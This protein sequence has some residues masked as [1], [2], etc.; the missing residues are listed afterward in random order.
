MKRWMWLLA[1]AWACDDASGDADVDP[2]SP[3][4]AAADVSVVGDDAA[5]PDGGS[6]AAAPRP[7]EV[8]TAQG[9]VRGHPA[10]IEG[11]TAFLG[12][13]FAAPPTGDLRWRPPEPPASRDETYAADTWAPACPQHDRDDQIIGE[14][15]CLYLNVWSPDTAGEAP[16][17]L[18]IHGGG[19]TQ[20]SAAQTTAEGIHIYDGRRLAARTGSVVV[21]VQYRLGHLGWLTHAE[22]DAE[23]GNSGN[24]GL[25]D[26]VA[27]LRWWQANAR[28]FGA[29]PGRVLVFGESAGGL[30]TCL[31]L[32]SPHAAGL[33]SAALMESG[34]CAASARAD[35]DAVAADLLEATACA[36]V[37]C[38]RSQSTDALL[39]A[40]PLSI[41]VAGRGNPTVSVDGD[42]VPD[43]PLTVIAAGEHNQV[44][45]VIGTNDAE[46][47]LAVPQRIDAAMYERLVR[48]TFGGFADEILAAY[49]LDDFATPRQAWV[50]VT[51]DAKFVCHARAVARA[52][53]GAQDAPVYRYLFAHHLENGRLGAIGAWHGL[54]LPFVFG[55]LN[56][57]GYTPSAGEEALSRE[58]QDRWGAFAGGSAPDVDGAAPWDV[59]EVE[60]DNHLRLVAGA[61][62]MGEG[63]HSARCDLW[64][65]LIARL[66][67]Q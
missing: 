47:A 50:Q 60:R 11:V 64:D 19:N 37:E 15:D 7:G 42:V 23:S 49:P 52:V 38:L 21:T 29:D 54:E 44:P 32:A 48:A 27:A 65:E 57:G 8:P 2:G 25:L 55:D 51:S 18:F 31:L 61:V 28:A 6:D 63:V 36:D 1:L 43:H 34:G 58:I 20:G 62:E 16:T 33:F 24:Y 22:L 39:A 41:D 56:V 13:P 59:Y 53:A 14:E 66:T 35:S 17:L 67:G 26:L 12:V 45:L 4:A 10:A 5:R 40:L 9:P 46:T 30:N 3:D